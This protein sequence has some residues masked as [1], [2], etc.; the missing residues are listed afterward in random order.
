MLKSRLKVGFSVM[1]L[2][3]SCL[4]QAMAADRYPTKPVRVIVPFLA[5][6]VTDVTARIIAQK[7]S[8][9]LGQPFI[10]DNRAGADSIIGTRAVK[11]APADGYTILATSNQFSIVPELKQDPGY[12]PQKDFRGVGPMMT[13]PFILDMAADQPYR[14]IHDFIADAK[15]NP[16]KIAFATPGTGSP[17]HLVTEMFFQRAGIKNLTHVPFKGAAAAVVEV[18]SG[19]IPFYVDAYPSSAPHIKS[20]KIRVLAVTSGKRLPVLPDVPTLAEQNI[21]LTY[22][23]WLGMLVRQGTPDDVVR[24][25]SDALRHA[26]ASREVQE[27]FKGDGANLTFMTP[28]EFDAVISKEVAELGKVIRDLKIEKQ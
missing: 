20:G 12:V 28:G 16:G 14:S 21:N 10:V 11:D 22:E 19:R 24:R 18:A 8:E 7:M 6:G 13:A 2:V 5:G 1:A 9:H 27:R 26:L 3:A 4:G 15:A 25:L 23:Y 17:N